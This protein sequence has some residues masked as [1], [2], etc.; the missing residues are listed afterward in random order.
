MVDLNSIGKWNISIA[1]MWTELLSV[2]GV[3]HLVPGVTMIAGG[4][5]WGNA[6]LISTGGGLTIGGIV[7]LMITQTAIGT[8]IIDRVSRLRN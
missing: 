2:T 4:L 7:I 8:W 3:L 5:W 1:S 6:A